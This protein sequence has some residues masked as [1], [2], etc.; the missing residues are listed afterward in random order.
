MRQGVET[1]KTSKPYVIALNQGDIKV[2]GGGAVRVRVGWC[3]LNLVKGL[4]QRLCL[5]TYASLLPFHFGTFS[6]AP[7][8]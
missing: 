2:P 4:G 3:K 6:S 5:C 1:S 7:C 8:N